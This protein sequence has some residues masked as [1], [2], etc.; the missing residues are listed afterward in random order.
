MHFKFKNKKLAFSII[1]DYCRTTLPSKTT[2][3][4]SQNKDSCLK[5]FVTKGSK[6]LRDQNFKKKE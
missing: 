4:T 1:L 6:G 3:K 5:A 2:R